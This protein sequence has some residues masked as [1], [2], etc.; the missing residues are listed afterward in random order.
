[1]E[2][3]CGVYYIENTVSH[4][5]YI[6]SSKDMEGRLDG[7]FKCLKRNKHGNAHL[8]NAFNKY[9]RDSFDSGT[10]LT[11]HLDLRRYYERQCVAQL[12]PN[13]YNIADVSD[14]FFTDC[15]HT[16]ESKQSMSMSWNMRRLIPVSEE[17]K[18]KMSESHIGNQSL[19][20]HICSEETKEKM[21]K[22][23]AFR[24]ERLG[25]INSPETRQKIS[26]RSKGNKWNVDKKASDETK[27]KL[28]KALAGNIRNKGH[29]ASQEARN[30]MS[31]AQKRRY[32]K[33]NYA[34]EQ[35]GH[36]D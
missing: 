33:A 7:H 1:M 34:K 14:A 6:G 31:E 19:K 8:Q 9:G 5:F 10:V 35:Y 2:N 3:I 26:A 15:K 27:L 28:S 12:K 25:Y 4:C 24:K 36:T 17:T 32:A 13:V 16:E 22:A 30:T 20:G 21:R 29:K 18:Q 23:Q 11:C